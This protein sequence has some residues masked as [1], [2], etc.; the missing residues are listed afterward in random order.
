MKK[1]F[2]A[3]LFLL[4]TN[5]YAE[6]TSLTCLD[7]KDNWTLVVQFDE[8]S[9]K[10]KVNYQEIDA[11]ID[12]NQIIW[13]DREKDSGFTINRS[14]GDL[15]IF[16]FTSKRIIGHWICSKSKKKF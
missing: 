11:L 7:P 2:F 6:Y 16:S 12:D 8:K 13:E 5:V 9:Q 3:F 10:V 14:N 4:T 15:S 1:Q